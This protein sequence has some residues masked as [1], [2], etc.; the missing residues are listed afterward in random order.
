MLP[1]LLLRLRLLLLLLVLLE[2][3]ELVRLLQRRVAADAP[4]GVDGA[5][6]DSRLLP[7]F[8]SRHRLQRRVL[9]VDRSGKQGLGN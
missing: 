9:L 5:M 7:C 2:G 6:R 1:C 3:L 8:S 4:A